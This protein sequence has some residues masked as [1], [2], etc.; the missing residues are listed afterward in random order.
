METR[1]QGVTK[2]Q[3]VRILGLDIETAPALVYTFSL[4][5][6][7]IGVDQIVKPGRVLCWSAKWFGEKKV[8]YCDERSG[9]KKMLEAIKE[10][11]TSADAVV[12]YNGDGFDLQKLNGEFVYHRIPPCPP[13]TSIDLWKTTKSLG[14]DSG[15]LAF[16]VRHLK[17][18][19]KVKNAGFPL[20]VG[21]MNG[22]E[23]CW[24]DMRQ[25]NITDTALLEDAYNILR[26]YIKNHP[27]MGPGCPVCQST[28]SQARGVRR[29]RATITQRMQC[30]DCGAWFAG[31]SRRAA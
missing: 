27:R 20:W 16:L 22:D 15:K 10:L 3:V 13:L 8:H 9:K 14:Y 6:T 7:T 11:M 18:G 5:D 30:Q 28:K 24:R 21:C 12:T 1:P 25:Y 31:S 26:P 29:T 4:R 19:E 23:K 17:I 2:G